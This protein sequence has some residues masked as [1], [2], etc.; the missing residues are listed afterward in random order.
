[1][2]KFINIIIRESK[3]CIIKQ[4]IMKTISKVLK[5]SYTIPTTINDNNHYENN[6]EGIEKVIHYTNY[7]QRQHLNT[8]TKT[9]KTNTPQQQHHQRTSNPT[10]QPFPHTSES[11]PSLG[12]DSRHFPFFPLSLFYFHTR[13]CRRVEIVR[14]TDV[15][16]DSGPA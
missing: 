8:T 7:N 12:S 16:S 14:K 11:K 10:V 5:K 4:I 3:F 6:F 1:M 13:H 9:N 2:L 15:P